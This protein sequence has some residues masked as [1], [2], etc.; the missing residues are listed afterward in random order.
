MVSP[1]RDGKI[2]IDIDIPRRKGDLPAAGPWGVQLLFL[3]FRR[4][5]TEKRIAASCLSRGNVCRWKKSSAA[6]FLRKSGDYFASAR[7]DA[8]ELS[9]RQRP[10]DFALSRNVSQFAEVWPYSHILCD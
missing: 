3:P 4:K 10:S 6:D 8:D 9:V 5:T 7:I 2:S 1:I